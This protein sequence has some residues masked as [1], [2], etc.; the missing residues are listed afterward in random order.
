MAG[1]PRDAFP[2][3]AVAYVWQQFVKGMGAVTHPRRLFHLCTER[4]VRVCPKEERKMR[5]AILPGE[6][7]GRLT[8]IERNGSSHRGGH[9]R[10]LYRCKCE[11]GNIVE[12]A[13]S[14]KLR[15]GRLKSCGC[16]LVETNVRFSIEAQLRDRMQKDLLEVENQVALKEREISSKEKLLLTLEHKI[17]QAEKRLV[18]VKERKSDSEPITAPFRF[19]VSQWRS[20]IVPAAPIPSDDGISVVLV[21]DASPTANPQSDESAFACGYLYSPDGQN[22]LLTVKDIESGK[23]KGGFLADKTLDLIERW[24]PHVFRYEHVQG[25]GMD[26]FYDLLF[27]KAEKRDIKLPRIDPF[28]PGNKRGEKERRIQRLQSLFERD[29]QPIG[30]A[31]EHGPYLGKFLQQIEDYEPGANEKGRLNDVLDALAMLAGFR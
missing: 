3:S 13:R 27:L 5:S 28:M 19:Q 16:L 31:L 14:D 9:A 20:A 29:G 4:F 8:V 26:W 1:T 15:D 18:E 21:L 23:W 2:F 25:Q 24:S 30:I 10:A 17:E 6:V 12:L 11:C 22:D 7:F